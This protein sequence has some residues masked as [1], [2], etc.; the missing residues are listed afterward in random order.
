MKYSPLLLLFL[1][2]CSSKKEPSKPTITGT[3]E[4][5]TIELYSGAKIDF[6]DSLY[7]ELHQQQSGLKLSFTDGKTFSVTQKKGNAPEQNIARQDYEVIGD[8]TLRLKNT[9]R[10][11]DEFRIISISDS[12]LKVNLF[13]SPMGYVVFRRVASGK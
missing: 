4:Y 8:T 9:G 2:A 6:T 11:D 13:N 12:L 7:N 10:P 1:L 5:K 3:W